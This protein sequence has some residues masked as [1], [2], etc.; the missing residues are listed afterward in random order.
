[1]CVCAFYGLVMNKDERE[2]CRAGEI[3]TR[4]MLSYLECVLGTIGRDITSLTSIA[5]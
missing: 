5:K 4:T 3:A 2:Q 1:M